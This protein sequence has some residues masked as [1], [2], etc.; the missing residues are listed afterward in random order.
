M[1]KSVVIIAFF[2]SFVSAVAQTEQFHTDMKL[3]DSFWLDTTSADFQN[4]L[5]LWENYK[6]CVFY[7][8]CKLQEDSLWEPKGPLFWERSERC[9]YKNPDWILQSLQLVPYDYIS[10]KELLIG[11]EKRNDTLFELRT[12]FYDQSNDSI[13]MRGVFTLPVVKHSDSDYKF[14]TKLSLIKPTLQKYQIGWLTFLYPVGYN[15]DND[16]AESTF[17]AAD[18]FVKALGLDNPKQFEYYLFETR[19]DFWRSIGVDVSPY[20]FIG[21]SRVYSGGRCF[22]ECNIAFYT[23]GGESSAHELLHFLI[24]QKHPERESSEFEEGVCSYF[25][26]HSNETK[27][28]LLLRLK[29]WLNENQQIDLSASLSGYADFTENYTYMIQMVI[30]EM[31]YKKGG[32]EMVFEMLFSISNNDDEYD[33]IEKYL[34]IKRKNLNKTFREYLNNNY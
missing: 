32:I 5:D 20:D 25:G 17:V 31:V 22:N 14:F 2:M 16:S 21:C 4:I 10:G 1:K 18:S 3:R 34:S 9:K 19:T 23:C 28:V 24:Y 12:M 27:D 8:W 11:I 7:D 29:D 15:F 13:K 26:G 6:F 30:C 33:A